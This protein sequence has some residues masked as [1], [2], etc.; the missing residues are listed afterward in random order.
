LK[1]CPKCGNPSYDGALVCG[2]CGH[3]FPKS[4]PVVEKK[5]QDEEEDIVTILKK[6]KLII[7]AILIIT[8]IAISA[9]VLYGTGNNDNNTQGNEMQSFSEGGISFTYPSNWELTNLTDKDHE[10]AYIFKNNE[11]TTLEYYNSSSGSSSLKDLTE[12]RIGNAQ[13]YGSSIEMIAPT[14]IYGNNGTDIIMENADGSYTRYV[15]LL[16]GELFYIFKIDGNNSDAVNNT[17]I[18]DILNSVKI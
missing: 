16:K 6:N 15:S 1:K 14:N 3:K 11:N 13:Y 12:Q 2:N 4:K 9:I 18:N 10:G 8:I 5:E 7:G 17:Q